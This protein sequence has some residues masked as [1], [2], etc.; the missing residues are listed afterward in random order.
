M[1]NIICLAIGGALVYFGFKL[2]IGVDKR[3]FER[4]NASGVEEHKD[5]SSKLKSNVRD[6][7][8]RMVVP[9]MWLI[10]VGFIV[11]GFMAK[12]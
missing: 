7:V 3:R 9:I 10:A 11:T 5:Y 1:G 6:N 2:W 4:T 8:T 12:F